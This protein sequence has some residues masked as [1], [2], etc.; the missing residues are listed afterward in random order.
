MSLRNGSQVDVEGVLDLG[1]LKESFVKT[2]YS[3]SE[4]HR[5]SLI[6]HQKPSKDNSRFDSAAAQEESK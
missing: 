5:A 2:L 4:S 6:E 3:E 1:S